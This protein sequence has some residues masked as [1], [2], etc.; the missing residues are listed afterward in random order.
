MPPWFTEGLREFTIKTLTAAI[1]RAIVSGRVCILMGDVFILSPGAIVEHAKNVQRR[2]VY[3]V[4]LPLQ[5]VS[6]TTAAIYRAR[7]GKKERRSL[8]VD[9]SALA[10]MCPRYAWNLLHW[11]GPEWTDAGG[12]H[13]FPC[14]SSDEIELLAE[15]R[16]ILCE[17]HT[18]D[19][20]TGRPF[21]FFS[22]DGNIGSAMHG[23]GLGFPEAPTVWHAVIIEFYGSNFADVSS[24]GCRIADPGTY[25]RAQFLMNRSGMDRAI[26]IGSQIDGDA[27]FSERISMDRGAAEEIDRRSA[28]SS[29]A[30]APD[31]KCSE[32]CVGCVFDSLCHGDAFPS[33]NCR[34][35]SH[36]LSPEAK[37]PC[38]KCG[39][40]Q[41]Q[42][43]HAEQE[44]ACEDH[45]YMPLTVNAKMT[46]TG[47]HPDGNWVEYEKSDGS[48]FVNS[49][50]RG[51]YKSAE[52]HKLGLA[53]AGNPTIDKI[54]NSIGGEVVL[55]EP[56]H[57]GKPQ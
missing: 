31:A 40:K 14:G 18:V 45:V 2:E 48:R 46:D 1:K 37:N 9:V 30:S 19:P 33:V 27:I 22:P 57:K 7:E 16:S 41:R 23:A 6:P 36:H 15:V 4:H 13:P 49:K 26:V 52:L 20:R 38:W 34:T 35:C 11:A 25:F 28:S 53:A 21:Y 47:Q 54:K 24:R 32:M 3:V 29:H 39:I 17:F 55:V 56:V 8:R 5:S 43:S 42:L 10:H 50:L 44:A 51:A 12:S